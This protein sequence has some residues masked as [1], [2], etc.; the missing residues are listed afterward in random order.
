[1]SNGT[2]KKIQ[3]KESL[4]IVHTLPGRVRFQFK[5]ETI[6]IPDLDDFLKIP[7]V[8]E[9]SFNKI[10]KSLLILYDQKKLNLEKLISEIQKRMPNLEILK[11][12][13]QKDTASLDFFPTDDLLTD[14]IC[15]TAGRANKYV[16]LKTKGQVDL[17]SLVPSGLLLVGLEE[18]IRKPC[19]PRWYDLWWF[20]YNILWQN[21]THRQQKDFFNYNF[22]K[23]NPR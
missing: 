12:Q 9:A 18:L 22:K 2:R 7:G 19:M 8:K 16:N 3:K 1:M 17:T 21:Y 14:I 20:G 13:S 11:A 4:E 23:T 10:T 5:S 6:G 15:Q